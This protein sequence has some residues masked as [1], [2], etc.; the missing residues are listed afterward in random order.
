M[1][2]SYADEIKLKQN[3]SIGYQKEKFLDN[4]YNEEIYNGHNKPKYNVLEK[5]AHSQNLTE[6]FKNI[7]TCKYYSPLLIKIVISHIP[8]KSR[9]NE[10]IV[11]CK[12]I[13]EQFKFKGNESHKNASRKLLH[14]LEQM[15]IKNPGNSGNHHYMEKREA[16]DK[17]N[18]KSESN[19][20]I[21][22]VNP[23]KHVKY[24]SDIN[25]NEEYLKLTT[26]KNVENNKDL[27]KF[28]GTDI[29]Y[30]SMKCRYILN[31]ADIE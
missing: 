21:V 1:A 31:I 28:N 30:K 20:S 18:I 17:W 4:N 26:E 9:D 2:W 19:Y 27:E 6:K 24:S 15:S 16:V 10:M 3:S 14:K 8:P 23:T 5:T 7:T 25:E 12:N 13:S 22:F 11:S 29:G